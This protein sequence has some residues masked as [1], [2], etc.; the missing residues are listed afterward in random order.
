MAAPGSAAAPPHTA[1]IGGAVPSAP[2]HWLTLPSIS[3]GTPGAPFLSPRSDAA[4]SARHSVSMVVGG[5]KSAS[6]R[7]LC[8]PAP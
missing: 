5:K 8:P 1:P 7:P 2:S 6:L 4:V 3:C